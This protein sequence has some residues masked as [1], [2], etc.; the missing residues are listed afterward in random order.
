MSFLLHLEG[1]EISK[2]D[3]C[4]ENFAFLTVSEMFRGG[5][6]HLMQLASC[7]PG[8]AL[9]R[10]ECSRQDGKQQMFRY[11][12]DTEL[13]RW[14]LSQPLTTCCKKHLIFS[15]AHMSHFS[16]I[17][18]KAKQTLPK[19]MRRLTIRSKKCTKEMWKHNEREGETLEAPLAQRTDLLKPC[20]EFLLFICNH[21]HTPVQQ[22]QELAT[23]K[24]L[25]LLAIENYKVL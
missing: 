24:T 12:P 14:L 25:N 15:K 17:N 18:C 20:A 9:V 22:L 8:I 1:Q 13:S 2:G 10:E 6:P 3:C 4:T 16:K 11:G 23:H 7:I 19:G 5:H 21:R